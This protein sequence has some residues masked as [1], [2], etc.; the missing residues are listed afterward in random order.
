MRLHLENPVFLQVSP[1]TEYGF[2]APASA[3]V[4]EARSRSSSTAACRKSEICFSFPDCLCVEDPQPSSGSCFLKGKL[5]SVWNAHSAGVLNRDRILNHLKGVPH[6]SWNCC[7]RT[8]PCTSLDSLTLAPGLP[9]P[10]LQLSHGIDGGVLGCCR[11][12]GR[13]QLRFERSLALL[14]QYGTE[15]PATH[16]LCRPLHEVAAAHTEHVQASAA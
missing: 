10:S 11:C 3:S 1:S 15:L 8:T 12:R 14:A 5:R 9:N 16:A 7:P 2:S 4:R 13:L 6:R